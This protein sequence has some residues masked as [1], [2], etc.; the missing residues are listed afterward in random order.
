MEAK[1]HLP[2]SLFLDFF[3][4]LDVNRLLPRRLATNLFLFALRFGVSIYKTGEIK[5]EKHER[6]QLPFYLG[7]NFHFLPQRF[8]KCSRK[9]Q[10]CRF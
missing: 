8:Q 4:H 3:L 9:L 1:L 10:Y 2:F 6:T 5:R 7:L